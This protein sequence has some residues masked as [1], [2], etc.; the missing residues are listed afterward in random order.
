M[1]GWVR[2]RGGG[3]V[4]RWGVCTVVSPKVMVGLINIQH[5]VISSGETGI[6]IMLGDNWR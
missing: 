2:G 1:R 4:E 3:G 5:V 6:S